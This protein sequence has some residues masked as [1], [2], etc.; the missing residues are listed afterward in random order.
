MISGAAEMML[1]CVVFDGSL[2]MLDMDIERRPYHRNCSCTLHQKKGK[3]LNT[4]V[5]G[6]NI[7]PK[8]Q[9]Q[10]DITLSITA[11]KFSSPSYSSS[12]NSP[13]PNVQHTTPSLA[14]S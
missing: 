9:K 1:Q 13:V 14:N 12:N 10:K 3:Q 2:P 6:R 11:S 4:C 5:H 8:R 7:S